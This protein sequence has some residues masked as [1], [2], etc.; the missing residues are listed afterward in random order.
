MQYLC[1]ACGEF[2]EGDEHQ[3]QINHCAECQGKEHPG[4]EKA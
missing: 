3:R 4:D 2:H 1:L